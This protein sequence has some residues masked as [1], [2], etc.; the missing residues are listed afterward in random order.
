MASVMATFS[1]QA[2]AAV[3]EVHAGRGHDALVEVR[4]AAVV[5]DIIEADVELGN[6]EDLGPRE[7]RLGHPHAGLRRGHD[8]R[9]GVGEPQGRRQVD[10]KARSVGSSGTGFNFTYCSSE[11]DRVGWAAEGR[12]GD[13]KVP[14][15]CVA[16]GTTTGAAGTVSG[17]RGCVCAG[18]APGAGHRRGGGTDV[19]GGAAGDSWA[20]LTTGPLQKTKLA[21][22]Q[23]NDQVNRPI[24]HAPLHPRALRLNDDRPLRQS[25]V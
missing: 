20:K 3:E 11:I 2:A 7:L 17:T 6:P 14:S 16:S 12:N 24:I 15:P 4:A 9:P 18:T 10:R 1:D 21:T 25:R 19:A 22:T 23:I 13:G 8:Q 5:P